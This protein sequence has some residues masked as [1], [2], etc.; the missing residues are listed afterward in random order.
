[1]RRT[2]AQYIAHVATAAILP[3]YQTDR[4]APAAKSVARGPKNSM[5]LSFRLQNFMFESDLLRLS[6]SVSHATV[7]GQ[8]DWL[9]FLFLLRVPSETLQMRFAE[10]LGDL[11]D[12]SRRKYNV[13][14]GVLAIAGSPLSLGE[15][16]WR[17]TSDPD[18][19]CFPHVCAMRKKIYH[20]RS[21]Q[22]V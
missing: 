21:V 18:V 16:H 19:F 8:A 15:F 20:G 2:F 5:G 10:D 9:S 11:S 4:L 13:I 14:V 7:V 22:C 3:G 1:M 12:F 6:K 17:E